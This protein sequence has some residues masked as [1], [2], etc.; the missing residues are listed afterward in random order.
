M[1]GWHVVVA[2]AIGLALYFMVVSPVVA[3]VLPKKS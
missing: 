1:K 2:V 3:S